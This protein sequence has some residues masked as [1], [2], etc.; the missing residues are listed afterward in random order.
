MTIVHGNFQVTVFC[1]PHGNCTTC[2][3]GFVKQRRKRFTHKGLSKP[4]AETIARNWAAYDPVV[5]PMQ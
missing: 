1:C 3:A 5:E 2:L 4:T